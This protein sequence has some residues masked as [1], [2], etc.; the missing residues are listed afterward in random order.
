[1]DVQEWLAS[2]SLSLDE[3]VKRLLDELGRKFDVL[4]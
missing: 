4:R 3:N 1:M 2:F